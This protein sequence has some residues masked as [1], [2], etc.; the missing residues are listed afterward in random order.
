MV[1]A[2][3]K[4]AVVEEPLG[5]VGGARSSRADLALED[6]GTIVEVKYARGPKDQQRLVEEFAQDVQ[7]YVKWPHLRY[8]VYFVYNSGD[9][10]DPDALERLAGDREVDARRFRVFVILA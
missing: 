6:L 7:L 8:F 5:K 2:Y 3:L 9:L 4:Y 10:R 1:R